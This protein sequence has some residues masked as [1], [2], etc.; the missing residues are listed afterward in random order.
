MTM[1]LTKPLL[2]L[3]LLFHGY[4]FAAH[5]ELSKLKVEYVEKPLGMDVAHPRFSW[6]MRA[7]DN[8]GGVRQSAFALMVKDESGTVVWDSGKTRSETSLNVEYGGKTLAPATRYDWSLKVW[9]QD[10]VAHTARSWF[11]TGLMGSGA[12]Q[13]AWSGAKRIGGDGKDAVLY[14]HYLPVFKI[15]YAMQLD[16]ASNSTRAGFVYGAN[17]RRLLDKNMNIGGLQAK[18]NGSYILLEI[19]ASPL[20]S[21]Q[22]ARLNIYRKGY[23]ADDSIDVPFKSFPIPQ[24]LINSN[25]VYEKH[26]V[27][28]SSNLGTSR[29][30]ID[31][32]GQDHLVADVNL[33]PFGQ[34]GDALAFP[35]VGDIGFHAP[36]DQAARFSDVKIRHFRSP[37]NAIFSEHLEGD[38]Y[39]GIS[40]AGHAGFAVENNAYR[41]TG[42]DAGSLVVADPSRNAMPMLRTSFT[43]AKASIAKAR[44]YVTA[45]GIYDVYLN[46]KRVGDDY[47]NPG[48][49]QYNKSHLYQTFDVT[50]YLVPGRNALGA[51]MGEGQVISSIDKLASYYETSDPR[52]N[53]LWENITWSTYGNFLS[54]PT[55]CPQRNGRLGWSGDISVF[56]RTAT[57]LAELPQFL[58]RHLRLARSRAGKERQLPFVGI[59]VDFQP[60]NHEEVFFIAGQERRREAV[61]AAA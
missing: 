11:E 56:S 30:Q 7:G 32:D 24:S 22:Q 19:D 14:A 42:G 9:D 15:D 13:A 53:K 6:Q 8:A 43:P 28:L 3:S 45:R 20:L 58:R 27:S 61:C 38:A 51:V 47:F 54:I 60:A 21:G 35:V 10:G 1:T 16:K 46:G 55:D 59:P 52:V 2:L 44:L 50:K 17:D 23:R 5:L 18:R 12:G 29:I 40:A 48:M 39:R 26:S 4:T 36:K 25:N 33:N 57:Y 49:T 37:S 41:I 31:C 34:G